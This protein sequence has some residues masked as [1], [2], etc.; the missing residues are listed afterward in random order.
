MKKKTFLSIVFKVL[1]LTIAMFILFSI[2]ASLAGFDSNRTQNATIQTDTTT[3]QGMV[4]L[5]LLL[6]CLI[7]SIILTY[8]IVRSNLHGFKLIFITAILYYG[9]KTF[10]S[11]IE[12]WY[13]MSNLTPESIPKLFLMTVPVV[14]IFPMIA[15][16]T[17]GKFK[18]KSILENEKNIQLK[19]SSKEWI[20]KTALLIVIVYPLL[21]FG[22]GYFIAWK[23]SE[24]RAFYNGTDPG[25]FFAQL[26]YIFRDDTWLYFFQLF[27]G[28]IWVCLALM[29]IKYLIGKVW[30]KSLFTGVLFSLLMTDALL[31]PNPFMPETVRITHFIE[32]ASSNFIWGNIIVILLFWNPKRKI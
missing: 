10:M 12:S 26:N 5:L 32:T 7:D 6:V 8:F 13:F 16:F 3:E 1:L 25:N 30:Q 22:F 19:I 27:R 17:L 9:I 15:V 2:G 23:N 4:A 18:K 29:N 31:I 20:W 28:L 24:L 11:Q 21:Y 14:I